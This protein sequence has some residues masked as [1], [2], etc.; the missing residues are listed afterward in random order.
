MGDGGIELK[1]AATP[2][3][4]LTPEQVVSLVVALPPGARW[5]GIL[6]GWRGAGK[7]TWCAALAAAA[8]ARG[9]SVAGVLSPA[10][11]ADGAPGVKVRID[12]TDLATGDT[13]VLATPAGSEGDKHGAMPS[14]G[15]RWHF[16]QETVEWGNAALEAARGADLVIIDEL[17]PLE[18]TH[19]RGLVAGLALL[20]RDDY[21]AAIAVIRP[22]LLASA[23]TRWPE[24]TVITV[25]GWRGV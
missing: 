24:A 3:R 15:L 2:D 11:F 19:G 20:D 18:F 23:L 21:R 1:M 6:T 14:H 8:R 22:E 9:L 17:G 12:L 25:P 7:T 4:P 10:V 5:L 16:C 13:R